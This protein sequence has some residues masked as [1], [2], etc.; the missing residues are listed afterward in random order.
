M[1]VGEWE[2]RVRSGGWVIV[3]EV[4]PSKMRFQPAFTIWGPTSAS[5]NLYNYL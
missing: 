1:N 5:F 4:I 2:Q 3:P